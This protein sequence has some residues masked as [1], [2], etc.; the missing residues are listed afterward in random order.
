MAQKFKLRFGDGTTLALDEAGLRTWV[1][2]GMVDEKTTVQPPGSKSW[3]PLKEFLGTEGGGKTGRASAGGPPPPGDSIKFAAI[4]D[5]PPPDEE[6]YDGEVRE[7]PL[8]VVWL[9]FKRLVL[10]CLI[11]IGLAA[12]AATWK[13]W[14]PPF[15]QF[16]LV[17]FRAIDDKIHPPSPSA[18]TLEQERASAQ[19]ERLQ[20]AT[21]QLPHLDAV[22]IQRVMDASM[23]G[24]ID[25]PEVFRRSHEAIA[26]GLPSLSGEELEEFRTLRAAL[27]GTLPAAE[28]ERLR[29]YDKTRAARVTLP[30]EDRD[31]LALTA[32]G[33]RALPPGQRQRL[34]ELSAKAVSAG[35]A[36]R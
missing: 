33:A 31:A 17:V 36:S 26:R 6:L 34:Q 7:S 2:K 13:E 28:R 4:D 21:E 10:I 19:R 20:A 16:G 35:L 3:H 5:G 1:S 8:W 23:V 12:A 25:P 27:V 29:E 22:T 9:W 15:T 32:R 18:A 24:A 14:L 11:V 30:F